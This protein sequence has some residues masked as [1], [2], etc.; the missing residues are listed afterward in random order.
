[1]EGIGKGTIIKEIFSTLSVPYVCV[2]C[3]MW[4]KE[5]EIAKCIA[6]GLFKES[7][8]LEKPHYLTFSNIGKLGKNWAEPNEISYIIFFKAERI[9]DRQLF[10][11]LLSLKLELSK[12]TRVIM[13]CS[14]FIPESQYCNEIILLN[15]N[16]L[17]INME[18]QIGRAHV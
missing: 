5:Q 13:V 2:N 17:I 3:A 16:F 14:K 1:M 18:P 9:I 8:I 10:L 12:Y 7:S 4:R 11:K 6:F 15:N